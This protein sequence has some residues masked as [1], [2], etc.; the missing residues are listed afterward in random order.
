[1]G[2]SATEKDSMENGRVSSYKKIKE[3]VRQER[4]NEDKKEEYSSVVLL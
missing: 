1:M 4:K 2:A 3:Y